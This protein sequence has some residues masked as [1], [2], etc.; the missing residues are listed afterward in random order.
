MNVKTK[1]SLIVW[2]I[3]LFFLWWAVFVVSLIKDDGQ[4]SITDITGGISKYNKQNTNWTWSSQDTK[5]NNQEDKEKT[6]NKEDE[7]TTNWTWDNQEDTK[8]NNIKKK[9][10]SLK[11]LSYKK[12][13]DDKTR[14]L[15]NFKYKK[16]SLGILYYKNYDNLEEY[17]KELVYKLATKSDDFDLAIIP[18]EW[19]DDISYLLNTSFNLKTPWFDISSIFDYNFNNYL[20]DN[21]IKAIPFAIDPIVW[22][23]S[24]NISTYQTFKNWKDIILKSDRVSEK[25][26]IK[27][28][29]VFLGYDNMYLNYL[30]DNNSLFPIFD[31]I[32]N[33]YIF[34]NS[35]QWVKLLKDFWTNIIYKTFDFKLYKKLVV[36]YRKYK[37]CENNEKM[38]FILDNDSTI[39]YDFLSRSD[40]YKENALNIY[41][42]FR[43]RPENI[44]KTTLALNKNTDEYPARWYIIIINPSIDKENLLIFLQTYIKMWKNDDLPFYKNL[45]SPF[46]WI[47]ITKENNFLSKYIWR[48]ITWENFWMW[49]KN[50]L[51]TKAL[52]YLKWDINIDLLF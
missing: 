33:Y 7:K 16:E 49:F 51:S 27:T 26:G 32:Y 2:W 11:I 45:I 14:K 35:K 30:E 31:Y 13:V 43:I 21:N 5:E 41:K 3:I 20:K 24:K 17:N 12:V 1:A 22:Y 52:N 18:S 39:V 37:F 28:M 48:F 47:W 42:N 40:F 50:N 15:F 19:F 8:L 38:C 25:D 23:T 10:H 29:P 9:E 4:S 46:V 34:K 44:Q 36:K 6:T